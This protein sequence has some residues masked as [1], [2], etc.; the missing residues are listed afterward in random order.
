[1]PGTKPRTLETNERLIRLHILPAFGHLTV[2]A[3]TREQVQDWFA[4]MSERP[5]LGALRI[6]DLR[7]T[8]ASHAV[9]SGENLPLVG[10]LLSHRRHRTTAGYANLADDHLV[11]A[12]E[13][14]GSIITA[15]MDGS[16]HR[17]KENHNTDKI[18]D[19]GPRR[20]F[21][22]D[23]WGGS[24]MDNGRASILGRERAGKVTGPIRV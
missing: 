10:K 7:H 6:H 15:T 17:P 18:G 20:R 2:D 4:S 1:M 24:R 11:E 13:K 23:P 21:V 5:G 9:M 19:C 22:F 12:A 3:V 16:V 14:V 8:I